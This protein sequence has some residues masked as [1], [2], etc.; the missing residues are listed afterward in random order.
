MR[1][2]DT[3][4]RIGEETEKRTDT[5]M[6][7]DLLEKQVVITEKIADTVPETITGVVVTTEM[8]TGAVVII[9]MIIEE[10]IT[11]KMIIIIEIEMKETEVT[12]IPNLADLIQWNLPLVVISET[13]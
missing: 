7:E 9:E 12:E 6:M 1:R 13:Y 4:M 5:E 11:E 10:V 8:T 2:E 3:V